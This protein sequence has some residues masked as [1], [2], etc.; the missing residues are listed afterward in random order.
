MT[1]LNIIPSGK[2]NFHYHLIGELFHLHGR[3]ANECVDNSI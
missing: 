1:L 3:N 2:N